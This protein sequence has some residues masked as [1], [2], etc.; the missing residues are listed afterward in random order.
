LYFL[1]FPEDTS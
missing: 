1:H